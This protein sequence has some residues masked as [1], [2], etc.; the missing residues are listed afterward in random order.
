MRGLLLAVAGLGLAACEPNAAVTMTRGGGGYELHF[1]N[2]SR[3]GQLL[4]VGLVEIRRTSAGSAD[5]P[6]CSLERVEGGEPLSGSWRYGEEVPG[7]RMRGCSPLRP[8]DAYRIH[9]SLG[10]VA[11]DAEVSLGTGGALA[12]RGGCT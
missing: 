5:E 9:V 3:P 1:D 11:A 7:Y 8:G 4:P 10:P 6:H 12:V 2:C